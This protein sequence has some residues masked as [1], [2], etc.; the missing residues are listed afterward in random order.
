MREPDYEEIEKQTDVPRAGVD[1]R[2][3]EGEPG[4]TEEL[5]QSRG[6]LTYAGGQQTAS[7]QRDVPDRPMRPQD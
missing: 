5:D 7:G 4:V 3:A 6:R 2:D 1:P